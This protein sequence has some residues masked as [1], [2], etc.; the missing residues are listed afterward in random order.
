MI[1]TRVRHLSRSG[2]RLMVAEILAPDGHRYDL[3][4][5]YSTTPI[6]PRLNLEGFTSGKDVKCPAATW[7][8][9][10]STN[11]ITASV[12]TA[13]LG[14]PRWVRV[15]LGLVAAPRDLKTSWADDSRVQGRVG[16]QHLDL[17]PR[18]HHA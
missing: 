2:Y 3:Q 10:R 15:G 6:G 11:R 5:D 13:C 1:Q 8:L 7:S 18:Q 17:G 14:D 12:P 9:H 16:D 4:V